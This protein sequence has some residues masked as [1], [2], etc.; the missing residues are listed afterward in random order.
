MKKHIWYE[1]IAGTFLLGTMAGSLLTTGVGAWMNGSSVFPDVDSGS[2]YD[3]AV[4]EMYGAGIIKGYADGKFGPNDYVTR[5]QVAV[6]MKRLRDDINGVTPGVSSSSRT[7]SS[8]SMNSSVSSVN[9]TANTTV[10]SFRF[11]S[12][13]LSI[14][15]AA[16][17]LT[18]SVLRSGGKQ[19][20]VAVAY[21]LTG[22]T[23]I[24]NTDYTTTS[25]VLSFANGDT[26]KNITVHLLRNTNATG[27]RTVNLVLSNPTNGATLVS[28]ST[29]VITIQSGAASG[30]SSSSSSTS[31]TVNTT[32]AGGVFAYSA[33]GYSVMENTG[34]ATITVVRTGTV[35]AAA[36]VDFTTAD[37]T[38]TNGTNYSQNSGT[39]SFASGE[40]SKT[41]T[42]AI[43]DNANPDGSKVV[44]LQL[45]NPTGG[46]VI[47]KPAPAILTIVDNEGVQF[48]GSGSIKFTYPSYTVKRSDGTAYIAV[49]RA[50]EF[51]G[52]ATVHYETFD[53]T[54]RNGTDYTRVTGT[55][56]FAA[57]ETQKMFAIPLMTNATP[58]ER[59]LSLRISDVGGDAIMGS[60]SDTTLTITD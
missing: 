5:A 55:L 22:G 28:P 42:V 21:T 51:D 49:T 24:A 10:G 11:T 47:G 45:R 1:F 16:S 9:N 20:S 52:V 58:G 7:R 23:A 43:I 31:G 13:S 12:A 56:T 14:P 30:G 54:A 4:G 15:N 35:S 25:G 19:G 37:G 59:Q 50:G 48:S 36:T 6:M 41:F 46:A 39:L 26:T 29:A 3:S 57:G 53:D 34:T 44:N 40:T 60:L 8:S 2:F 18:V 17:T 33:G 38:G 27:D 32:A